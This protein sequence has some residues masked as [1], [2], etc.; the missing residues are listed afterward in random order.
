MS[1][2]PDSLQTTIVNILEAKPGWR[3]VLQGDT[4]TDSLRVHM[5]GLACGLD[6]FIPFQQLDADR[7]GVILQTTLEGMEQEIE[8]V[9]PP[10]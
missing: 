4:G 10:E 7:H 8:Q 3:I 2:T 1:N 5:T 9:E 6:R